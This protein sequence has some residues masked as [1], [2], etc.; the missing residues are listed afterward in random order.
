MTHPSKSKF[1]Q[2]FERDKGRCVYCG[3]D[4]TADYDRF[5]MATEDHLIPVSR[6]GKGRELE[7]LILSCMVCNRLKENYI[8]ESIDIAKD[9]RKY[10]AAIREYIYKRRSEKLRE[11]MQV[12]HPDQ[13]DY[14]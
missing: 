7:N 10:I 2:L 4:L 9:R 1:V 13:S 5:M 11:F 8:P 3:M 6:G 14:R 12:T